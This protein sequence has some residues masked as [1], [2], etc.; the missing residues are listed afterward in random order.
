MAVEDL[1]SNLA[2][3]LMTFAAPLCDC[4]CCGKSPTFSISRSASYLSRSSFVGGRLC[5]EP[6]QKGHGLG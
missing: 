2:S 4:V 1:A 5:E 6:I 3:D